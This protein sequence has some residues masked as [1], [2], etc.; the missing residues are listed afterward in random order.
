MLQDSENSDQ[1]KHKSLEFSLSG[2]VGAEDFVPWMQK[3]A[4]KLGVE[5]TVL[6]ASPRHLSIR[7][8]GVIEMVD[9]FVL[10]CSLGPQSVCIKDVVRTDT[11]VSIFGDGKLSNPQKPLQP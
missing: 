6:E 1:H 9:A 8:T 3:H 2:H 10:A 5:F 7:T 4:R 11:S